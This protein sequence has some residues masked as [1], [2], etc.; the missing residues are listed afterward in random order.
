MKKKNTF[1]SLKNAIPGGEGLN[2]LPTAFIFT[3]VLASEQASVAI[4]CLLVT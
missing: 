2:A 4:S 3:D 1:H